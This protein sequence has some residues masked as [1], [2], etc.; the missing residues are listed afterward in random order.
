MPGEPEVLQPGPLFPLEKDGKMPAAT[1]DATMSSY[2]GSG[3]AEPHELF[4]TSGAS[5][6]RGLVPARLVGATTHWPEAS[7]DSREQPLV[8]QPFAAIH[9]AP[10]ATPT[11][12]EPSSPTIVPIV[13]V[14]W[15]LLSHGAGVAQI[16]AGSNQL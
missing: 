13:W 12:F 10:G 1:Q 15:L 11:W 8:S 16:R 6:G 4:T 5:S 3:M 14:P 9:L 2:H 7:S